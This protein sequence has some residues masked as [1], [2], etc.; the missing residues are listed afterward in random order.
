MPRNKGGN[1]QWSNQHKSSMLVILHEQGVAQDFKKFHY[2]IDADDY[3][4]QA[5]FDNPFCDA[6]RYEL[7]SEL[8]YKANRWYI[9]NKIVWEA[10]AST[11]VPRTVRMATLITG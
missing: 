6:H 9:S 1:Y 7:D 3:T 4:K 10:C 5:L 8:W 11:A 2:F